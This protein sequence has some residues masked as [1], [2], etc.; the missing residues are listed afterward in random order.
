MHATRHGGPLKV[1]SLRNTPQH[2]TTHRNTLQHT[3]THCN[4]LQHRSRPP[5]HRL[6]GARLS[7]LTSDSNTNP[8]F[9]PSNS[10]FQPPSSDFQR[11]NSNTDSALKVPYDNGAHLQ[12]NPLNHVNEGA[13]P[14]LVLPRLA[15]APTVS[16]LSP[17]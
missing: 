17:V 14:R 15:P 13:L 16:I 11:P 1:A 6:P 10:D 9:Q 12:D 8:D 7:P 2:T 4:T 3:T 5:S